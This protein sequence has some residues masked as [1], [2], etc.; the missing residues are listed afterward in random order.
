MIFVS[1][2]DFSMSSAASSRLIK[3]KRTKRKSIS[4]PQPFLK[5]KKMLGADKRASRHIAVLAVKCDRPPFRPSQHCVTKLEV[6]QVHR[7]LASSPILP[8]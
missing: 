2:C 4:I 1:I 5:G 7:L 3:G 6:E 8:V